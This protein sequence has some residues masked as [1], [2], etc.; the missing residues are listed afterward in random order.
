MPVRSART[1]WIATLDMAEL[2]RFD[3]AL[4]HGK[5]SYRLSSQA[6]ERLSGED[7]LSLLRDD[8][9]HCRTLAELLFSTGYVDE[10]KSYSEKALLRGRAA[11][12]LETSDFRDRLNLA[13]LLITLPHTEL[14]S[15]AAALEIVD[16]VFEQSEKVDQAVAWRIRGLAHLRAGGWD[17]SID[18][19]KQC[20]LLRSTDTRPES[21]AI[22]CLVMA[23]ASA[24]SG[25]D[26]QARHWFAQAQH[27]MGRVKSV[28][29]NYEEALGNFFLHRADEL[30]MG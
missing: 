13:E 10:S 17:R 28:I 22:E 24:K 11:V 15:P 16:D 9:I 4:E 30:M 27:S 3:D 20:A 21:I 7:K 14:A 8:V 29:H 12:E 23:L 18:A 26:E 25:T 5:E 6:L 19:I 2:G 1:H